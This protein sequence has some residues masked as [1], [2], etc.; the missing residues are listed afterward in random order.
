M[1]SIGDEDD[2]V[3]G[4]NLPE[5][6]YYM[7][8]KMH[9]YFADIYI[10]SKNMIIEVKSTYTLVADELKNKL[11]RQACSDAGYVFWFAIGK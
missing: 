1:I 9:R 3:C 10:K 6:W 5:I 8:N 2:I 11:K 4:K 7:K